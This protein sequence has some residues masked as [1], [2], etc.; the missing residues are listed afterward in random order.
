MSTAENLSGALALALL[1]TDDSNTALLRAFMLESGCMQDCD[2]YCT[3][4]AGVSVQESLLR[5]CCLRRQNA[6]GF[7]AN[8]WGTWLDAYRFADLLLKL[9][10][11]SPLHNC[12]GVADGATSACLLGLYSMFICCDQQIELHL[13]N[14]LLSLAG[15]LAFLALQGAAG[16]VSSRTCR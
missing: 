15:V 16:C 5:H 12:R 1:F 3:S 8:W 10:P 9:E 14:V 7:G 13:S 4:I 11:I 6:S 2:A